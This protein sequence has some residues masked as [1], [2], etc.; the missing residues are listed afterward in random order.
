MLLL[1][2]FTTP[3]SSDRQP[4]STGLLRNFPNDADDTARQVNLQQSQAQHQR[5]SPVPG[6][7]RRLSRKSSR[8]NPQK[9]FRRSRFPKGTESFP[10]ERA[11]SSTLTGFKD[12]EWC[13]EKQTEQPVPSS[14]S[15]P[16]PKRFLAY[17]SVHARAA[18]RKKTE[19]DRDSHAD[20]ELPRS[21]HALRITQSK[22][23]PPRRSPVRPQS[24]VEYKAEQP[25]RAQRQTEKCDPGAT[26]VR[27]AAQDS[28]SGV[29]GLWLVHRDQK[30]DRSGPG[31]RQT[32]QCD[33][34]ATDG[35]T[36]AQDSQSG[37]DGLRLVHRSE[38]A[39]RLG[40]RRRAA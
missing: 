28:Q 11:S 31:R 34:G 9:H 32:E 19:P 6:R 35:R 30:A 13:S 22:K 33:L 23:S 1:P 14:S 2:D 8:D 38:K 7:G 18:G 40:R 15:L 39:D 29:D 12:A 5:R 24:G 36:A 25:R 10:L 27:T 3:R 4:S 37:V 17:L 16:D 21:S 26:D 20:E